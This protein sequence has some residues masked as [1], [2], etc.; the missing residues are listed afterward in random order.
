M[1]QQ[2]LDHCTQ[3]DLLPDS[4]S[5]YRKG[6]SVETSIIKMTSDILWGFEKQKYQINSNSTPINCILHSRP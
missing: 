6:L 2:L 3:Q 5:V 4:Q 1:L